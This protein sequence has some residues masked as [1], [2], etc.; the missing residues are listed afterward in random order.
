[1]TNQTSIKQ[2]LAEL[3]KR[4]AE[5]RTRVEGAGPDE[6]WN[7][8]DERRARSWREIPEWERRGRFLNAVDEA[9]GRV[10]RV[11]WAELALEAGYPDPRAANGFFSGRPPVARRDDGDVVLTERGRKAAE[12]WRL[13]YGD[14]RDAVQR[15]RDLAGDFPIQD[16]SGELRS[17]DR[18]I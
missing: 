7:A 1:M 13:R 8:G 11:R 3:E 12:Y 5:L 6:D 16:L 17:G 9:G 2:A 4:V 15:L 10:D 18:R 14:R